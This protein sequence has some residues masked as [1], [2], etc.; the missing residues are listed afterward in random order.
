[1]ATVT[2]AGLVT[3]V[4][5]GTATIYVIHAGRQGQQQV[6]V[7]PNYQGQW[8]GSYIIRSCVG[9]TTV[10]VN[11]CNDQLAV[12]RVYPTSMTLT[13]TGESISGQVFLG[14]IPFG[15]FS[16]PITGQGDVTFTVTNANSSDA[17]SVLLTYRI[18]AAVD[19]RITGRL[20]EIVRAPGGPAGEARVEA[21]I[22]DWLNRISMLAPAAPMLLDSIDAVF[23]ALTAP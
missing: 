21:D 2:D 13:Q 22:V 18:N 16:A 20:S 11:I 4:S 23:D 6:R 17:F 14:Q 10:F 5:N 3:G 7:L 8:R 12:N 1:V 9:T 19:G 15:N